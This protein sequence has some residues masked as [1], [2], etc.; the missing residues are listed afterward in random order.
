MKEIKNIFGSVLICMFAILCLPNIVSASEM[1]D[2]FKTILNKDG[3]LEVNSVLPKNE[4]QAGLLI[5]DY[6][7]SV[8]TEGEFSFN[9][10]TCN[11][12]YTV[13]DIERYEEGVIVETHPVKILYVYNENIKKEAERIGKKLDEKS[14]FAVRDLEVVNFWIN[15]KGTEDLVKD[16]S[17]ELKEYFDFKNFDFDIRLGD[18]GDFLRLTGGEGNIVFNNTIYYFGGYTEV[19]AKNVLYVPENTGNSKEELI[20]AVQKRINE[21][22][23][24][25]VVNI[26]YGGIVYD[27]YVNGFDKDILDAQNELNLERAKPENEQDPFKIMDL[28]Y[29][30]SSNQEYK[31]DFLDSWNNKNGYYGFLAEA[32]GGYYFYATIPGN[33]GNENVFKFII[34]KDDDKMY[35]PTH[36]TTD[37]ITNVTISSNDSSVPL[38]TKINVNELSSGKEYEKITSILNLTDSVTFDL[39]LY[40]NSL[41]EYITKLENGE[42][43]VKIPIPKN[44]KEKDLVVYYVKDNGE[45]E[46]YSVDTTSEPGY[47]KFTTTHF[48]IYT[49][50][51][52]ENSPTKV[53]VTFDA[54]GGKF[55]T[56][57]TYTINDWTADMYDS[58]TKPTRD[59]YTFKGYFTE[60]TGGTKIEM[61]LNESGIEN[62]TTFYAQWEKNSSGGGVD[63]SKKEPSKN[64]E[65]VPKTFD[66]IT[67]SIFVGTIS[68]IGLIGS[69][70]YLNKKRKLKS[71]N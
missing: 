66:G 3:Y 15:A 33:A 20:N 58:L 24:K 11:E 23:G 18:H 62:N 9:P 45:K 39:K 13:C 32:E 29:K 48:S 5:G 37:V 65:E 61:I 55:E 49:L 6:V 27:Y 57:N 70:I 7:L 4:M 53:K 63:S 41:E 19:E 64:E 38:D 35:A 22:V 30:I 60:K 25:D 52:T 10:T 56:E 67:N 68:L 16:Y 21:Y 69:T 47:A 59:G 50:G 8:R 28:E 46:P 44:F 1:S 54:N 14:H 36:A 43:E 40:S 17:T 31:N 2:K 42:F 71:N 12:N 34:V 26:S 51:Y